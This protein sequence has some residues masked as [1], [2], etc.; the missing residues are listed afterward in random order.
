MRTT[1]SRQRKV[2]R[3][4][5]ILK[6]RESVHVLA[7][8]QLRSFAIHNRPLPS[9]VSQCSV[10]FSSFLRP[11]STVVSHSFTHAPLAIY[12][13]RRS[14]SN[15]DLS[16]S[17]NAALYLVHHRKFSSSIPIRKFRSWPLLV[18]GS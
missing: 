16:D 1:L 3:I 4:K 18:R 14:S 13:N 2:G 7:A 10:Y 5:Y 12:L 6:L 8:W 11:Y 15:T 17:G 9:D